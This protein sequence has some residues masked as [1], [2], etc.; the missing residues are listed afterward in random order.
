MLMIAGHLDSKAPLTRIACVALYQS[1]AASHPS[2]TTV[3]SSTGSEE[4]VVSSPS[5]SLQKETS[6]LES[7]EMYHHQRG[8]VMDIEAIKWCHP[9]QPSG[10]DEKEESCEQQ[11][12]LQPVIFVRYAVTDSA[13]GESSLDHSAAEVSDEDISQRHISCSL[14]E[15]QYAVSL[16]QEQEGCVDE[17]YRTK[18]MG[19]SGVNGTVFRLSLLRPTLEPLFP[20]MTA[21]LKRRAERQAR[22]VKLREQ[23]ARQER[24][25]EQMMKLET[26]EQM[27]NDELQMRLA[28]GEVVDRVCCKLGCDEWALLQCPRCPN[29]CY[30]RIERKSLFFIFWLILCMSSLLS[31]TCRLYAILM[32]T[33]VRTGC[34]GIARYVC[35]NNTSDV[36]YHHVMFVCLLATLI[37]A[38]PSK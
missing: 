20:Y 32:Q 22:E 25:I 28:R 18:W 4:E 30:C 15:I 3:M 34:N 38:V 24:R 12:K 6:S 31:L 37:R 33:N 26:E 14:E 17:A 16:L 1:S 5:E 13:K 19:K 21:K 35:R 10:L 36:R 8:L 2:S 7:G 9:D 11:R 27:R 23:Q 29:A